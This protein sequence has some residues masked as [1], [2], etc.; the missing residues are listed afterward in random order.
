MIIYT[1]G[2][3]NKARFNRN[4][5]DKERKSIGLGRKKNRRVKRKKSKS[6]EKQKIK[7]TNQSTKCKHSPLSWKV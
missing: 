6:K 3:T 1:E 7:G 2:K 4:K 5:A